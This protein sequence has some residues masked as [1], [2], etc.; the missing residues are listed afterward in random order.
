MAYDS[1]YVKCKIGKFIE[2]E[3]KSEVTSG[4]GKVRWG[5]IA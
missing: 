1:M 3:S 4:W 5:V 2:A